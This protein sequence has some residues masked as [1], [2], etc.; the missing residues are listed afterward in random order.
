MD[1]SEIAKLLKDPMWRIS[2]LYEIKLMD[3]FQKKMF[4]GGTVIIGML[5]T[6][7]FLSLIHI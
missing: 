4:M 1:V 6:M 2:H 3:L 7:V 5:A